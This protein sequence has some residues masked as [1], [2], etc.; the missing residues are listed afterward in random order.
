M[1]SHLFCSQSVTGTEPHSFVYIHDCLHTAVTGPRSC[2]TDVWPMKWKIFTSSPFT[3]RLLTSILVYG[4]QSP[5]SLTPPSTLL[6][7]LK[8]HFPPLF[9]AL[10]HLRA[11]KFHSCIIKSCQQEWCHLEFPPPHHSMQHSG[12]Q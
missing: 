6:S 11:G 10:Q 4:L 1:A 3:E 5:C 12:L 8:T 2:H 7:S 9:M